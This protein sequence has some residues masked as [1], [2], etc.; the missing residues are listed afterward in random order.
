MKE[1]LDPLLSTK[2]FGQFVSVGILG[3]VFDLSVSSA[4]TVLVGVSPEVSKLAG[5][6]VA[7]VVMF[8][9]N[10]YWTF[11][12]H[13][14]VGHVETFR[15]FLRSNLVR[16]GGVAVQVAV[17]W[18]LGKAPVEYVVGGV[19]LWTLATFPIAIGTAFL[20]NYVLESTFTWRVTA[21]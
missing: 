2:R 19:D 21:E 10:E 17:V 16:V 12:Q 7:I 20:L 18:L 14:A 11:A 5:A 1:K 6:E 9:I 15:R 4:L 8:V 3:S 13:G